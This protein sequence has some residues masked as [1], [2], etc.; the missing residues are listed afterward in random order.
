[1]NDWLIIRLITRP[2]FTLR[3]FSETSPIKEAFIALSLVSLAGISNWSH[4]QIS[5]L[6]LGWA[7]SFTSYVITVALLSSILDF[8]AQLFKFRAQSVRLFCWLSLSLLPLTLGIPLSQ[9]LW[10][11]PSLTSVLTLF[12]FIITGGI[13]YF[14]ILVIKSLYKASIGAS[15]FIYTS[16]IIL[17]TLLALFLISGLSWTLNVLLGTL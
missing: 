4:T 10:S 13:I 9:F 16:P 12:A 15:L 11:F 7:V 8:I 17:A 6:G 1:M 14:Q 3:L 5:H 2:F